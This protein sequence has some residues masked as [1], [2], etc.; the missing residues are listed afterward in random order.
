MLLELTISNIAIIDR[1]TLEFGPGLAV[2]TGET[3]AGKSILVDA[4]G[5]VLGARADP[6]LIR[7]GAET[8]R[9]EGVFQVDD[10]AANA[11]PRAAP[12][13]P[14]AAL[15]AEHGIEPEDG[16]L[17]LSRDLQRTGRSI[18]RINGRTVM[19]SVLQQVG[20]RLVDIHGQSEH[21]SLLRPAEHIE[22]LDRYA[23][24]LGLRAAVAERVA[25]LG[26]LRGER[27]RLAQQEQDAAR[28]A[29]LLQFQVQ[30]ITAAALQPGEQEALAE[31][32]ALLSNAEQRARLAH[33]VYAAL[34]Q[35]GGGLPGTAD[36]L[37]RAVAD[38]RELARLDG[39]LAEQAASLEELAYHL[40]DLAR[41]LRAYRDTVEFDPARLQAAS[42]RLELVRT[43]A[44]K[45]GGSVEAVLRFGAEAAQELADLTHRQEQREELDQAEEAAR[46]AAGA[47]AGELSRRRAV[48]ALDLARAVEAE[49]AALHL[50]QV[51]FAVAVAQR[52]NPDGLP[53][54]QDAPESASVCYAFDSTGIDTVEFHISVNPGE[55]VRPLAKV[56]SGGETSRVML[57]LKTILSRADVIGTL[58]FDEV[59]AGLGGQAG[60]AVGQK[61]A[62][63]GKEHQVVAI[64]HLPQIA[65]FG[66]VH[67]AIAKREEGGRTTTTAR[68][69]RA[70][71]RVDEIARMIGA[72]L[73]RA[74]RQAAQD[75]LHRAQE[76]TRGRTP[77]PTAAPGTQATLPLLG[78]LLRE[79]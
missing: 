18:A 54:T 75:L 31:E 21:L 69:L 67:F 44:R 66:E 73:T 74:A 45:Y 9:V 42:E 14:L 36:L 37:A 68:R 48:A 3:G 32:I 59:D 53:V 30:E 72:G 50:P 7:A 55:P 6:G 27:R 43:L 79:A 16:I 1:Q 2:I 47:L 71:E 51:R 29:E 25:A 57:A 17:V 4:L 24:L 22:F 41:A 61:L 49:L 40:G 26:R 60:Y 65:A 23:G 58:I 34:S 35:G 63:L 33:A 20:Q 62:Q 56:A 52:E 13:G 77:G 10:P 38:A 5:L 46:R 78:D 8:A 70:D 28:R 39:R 19:V 64:T 11:E 76:S 15:L 12:D